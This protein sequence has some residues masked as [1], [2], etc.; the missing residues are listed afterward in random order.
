M[1]PY[2]EK[3]KVQFLQSEV[4]HP[5]TKGD[6]IWICD[7]YFGWLQHVGQPTLKKVDATV[8]QEYI[9]VTSVEMK[10]ASLYNVRLY[11]R[12]LYRFLFPA[13][14]SNSDYA[15]LFAFRISRE[16]LQILWG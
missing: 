12:K 14:F 13:G 3:I 2:Y 16:I 11:M 1:S 5:N 7:R 6:I 4:F 10:A 9:K 15:L 8:I